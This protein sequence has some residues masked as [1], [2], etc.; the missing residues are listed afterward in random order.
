LLPLRRRHFGYQ[1][2]H[3]H[4]AGLAAIMVEPLLTAQDVARILRVSVAWVYDHADRKRPRLPSVRLGK[5]VRFRLEDV[6]RF[7]EAM[8]RRAA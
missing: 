6:E 1:S 7:I 4:P 3:F 8:S 2:S 5:A